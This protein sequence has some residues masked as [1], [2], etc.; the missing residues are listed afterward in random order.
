MV[1]AGFQDAGG[2]DTCYGDSG[3]PLEAPLQGGGYRLVGITG[4][5]DGCA[6]PGAPGVYTRVAGPTMRSLIS[7]DVSSLETANGLTHEGIFGSGGQP[8]TGSSSGSAPTNTKTAKSL[9]KCKRI[10]DKKK[11]RRCVKKVKKKARSRG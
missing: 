4:W 11:R 5:G 6:Q 3:G 10:H 7:S 1:C 8:R 2:V 9:K